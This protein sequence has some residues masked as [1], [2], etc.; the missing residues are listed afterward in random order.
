[1]FVS[2]RYV[3]KFASV[4]HLLFRDDEPLKDCHR[5]RPDIN[6]PVMDDLMPAGE[7]QL[8][9]DMSLSHCQT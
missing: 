4:S 5:D 6:E 3:K 7:L 2:N 1:M 9:A 8:H